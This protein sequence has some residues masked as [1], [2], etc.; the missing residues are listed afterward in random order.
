MFSEN[1]IIYVCKFEL[2]FEKI[3]NGKQPQNL[4]KMKNI[5]VKREKREKNVSFC[6]D[7]FSKTEM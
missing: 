2:I 4:I 6:R 1:V 5:K 3:L 7:Q